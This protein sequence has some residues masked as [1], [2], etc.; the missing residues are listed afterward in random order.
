MSPAPSSRDGSPTAAA[1][2]PAWTIAWQALPA[3]RHSLGPAVP[4]PTDEGPA[5]PGEYIGVPATDARTSAQVVAPG[6]LIGEA[7]RSATASL[8][9][10]DWTAKGVDVHGTPDELRA[11]VA[12]L[13]VLVDG[14]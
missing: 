4:A 6:A 2:A 3:A 1:S 12:R 5:Y 14:L 10:G 8:I 9:F 13:V 7:D 11:W